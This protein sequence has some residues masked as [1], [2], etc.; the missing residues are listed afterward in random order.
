M[1]SAPVPPKLP[2]HRKAITK[3]ST[4]SMPGKKSRKQ[5]TDTEIIAF[6]NVEIEQL[7]NDIK[8]AREHATESVKL[9]PTLTKFGDVLNEHHQHTESI[10]N[11]F[12]GLTEK[13]EDHR[14]E[15]CNCL[16]DT[17]M[18]ISLV[19][20]EMS[21][22]N[23]RLVE[24]M[25]RWKAFLDVSK[26]FVKS[27]T[28]YDKT[29][30]DYSKILEKV[31]QM[32]AQA[33]PDVKKAAALQEQ[34]DD[35]TAKTIKEGDSLRKEYNDLYINF[36]QQMMDICVKYNDV[37]KTAPSTYL[38][39]Q[40][41][42]QEELEHYN[43][44]KDEEINNDEEEKTAPEWMNNYPTCFHM[45]QTETMY[46]ENITYLVMN[47]A[48]KIL[49]DPTLALCGL[50][51]D[52][53][54]LIFG[55]IEL[56]RR[57]HI[58][59]VRK[60][61]KSTPETFVSIYSTQVPQIYQVY[62]K[63]CLKFGKAFA[64]FQQCLTK[65]PFK[66][67]V[68]EIATSNK[69]PTLGELLRAPFIQLSQYVP[70]FTKL[71]TEFTKN[72]EDI[73]TLIYVFTRIAGHCDLAETNFATTMEMNK[74]ANIPPKQ[75][76]YRR[77]FSSQQCTINK[78]EGMMFFFSDVLI[79]S[80]VINPKDKDYKDMP[81]DKPYIFVEQ[82]DTKNISKF[83]IDEKK[84]IVKVSM[85]QR[86]KKLP[87]LDILFS[88]L[89]LAQKCTHE[90]SQIGYSHKNNKLFGIDIKRAT[91]QQED[92]TRLMPQVLHQIFDALEK[93]AP[94]TEGIFRL[95][96]NMVE[97][98]GLIY[99]IDAGGMADDNLNDA[100]LLA[101]VLKKYC[102][103][104]PDKLPV[105]LQSTQEDEAIQKIL[106][107]LDK[108]FLAFIER[109][110]RLLKLIA[111]NSKENLMTAENLSKVIAPNIYP[112]E[113]GTFDVEKLT[114]TVKH[115][116]EA[117]DTVFGTI[118]TN[119]EELYKSG[120]EERK[121]RAKFESKMM[122]GS[123]SDRDISVSSLFDASKEDSVV[124]TLI[125]ILRQGEA[126][127]EEGKKTYTRWVVLKRKCMMFFKELGQA[128]AE[129]VIPLSTCFVSEALQGTV[130]NLSLNEKHFYTLQFK[131]N[132]QKW[133][134]LVKSCMKPETH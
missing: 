16:A 122:Q 2:A 131:D 62:H 83:E 130:L 66:K 52:D 125:D 51:L 110:F 9:L 33:K 67:M 60:L 56:I 20:Y 59:I 79:F 31:K 72:D 119:L 93:S 25:Q 38:S 82:Y 24:M 85:A 69:I 75:P 120:E 42:F 94:Q 28:E 95:S 108:S 126:T 98:D 70:I 107:G 99:K 76:P 4:S 17:G 27:R 36:M 23:E 61:V 109:L 64:R 30:K 102:D 10:K 41:Q 65:E 78:V 63:H 68:D 90:L 124:L 77:F 89:D 105:E 46:V 26:D 50:S 22:R 21:D 53:V 12:Q 104:L 128:K 19:S 71:K 55:G 13:P 15:F 111:D 29:Y 48:K 123:M 11:I 14:K 32:N 44:V 45:F 81:K 106:N 96:S 129:I 49:F 86:G 112:V 57:L 74:I 35:I 118:K 103:Q 114:G 34:K 88:K 121:K 91:V 40:N 84:S 73:E 18:I 37:M 116:I 58:S 47:Y 97:L 80:K 115:M 92:E 5:M 113:T 6:N 1:S 133:A 134:K 100:I 3:D 87:D 127:V 8:T 43:Q 117:Y 7:F 132:H 39:Y 54:N 101:N